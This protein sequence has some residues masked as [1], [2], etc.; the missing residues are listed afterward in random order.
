MFSIQLYLC[1]GLELCYE[2]PWDVMGRFCV[3]EHPTNCVELSFATT[4]LLDHCV[5]RG[6][7]GVASEIEMQ[8]FF[9]PRWD[10]NAG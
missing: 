9:L 10:E 7:V 1:P 4:A 8:N 2:S 3:A 6:V 5:S